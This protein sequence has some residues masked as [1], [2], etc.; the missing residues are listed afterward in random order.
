MFRNGDGYINKN[1]KLNRLTLY[2]QVIKHIMYRQ[3]FCFDIYEP[4]KECLKA[5]MPRLAKEVITYLLFDKINF[6]YKD[7]LNRFGQ[8]L[9]FNIKRSIARIIRMI[10]WYYYFIFSGNKIN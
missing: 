1:F 10:N 6:G 2:L 9:D 8:I 4:T 3:N 7:P 5:I